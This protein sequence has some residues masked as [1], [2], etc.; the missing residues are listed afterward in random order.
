MVLRPR[1]HCP[2]QTPPL[3]P[4]IFSVRFLPRFPPWC[5]S[6][7][8][9]PAI[10]TSNRQPHN[11][12][13]DDPHPITTPREVKAVCPR[14]LST[15]SDDRFECQE[16]YAVCWKGPVFLSVIAIKTGFIVVSASSP[17][18]S[19]TSSTPCPPAPPGT[20]NMQTHPLSH[21]IKVGANPL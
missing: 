16:D 7:G 1:P 4:R 9:R 19:K 18:S 12:T 10:P 6:L 2:S 17:T 15:S 21:L 3:P 14:H 13:K 11:P 20:H 5:S 8:F